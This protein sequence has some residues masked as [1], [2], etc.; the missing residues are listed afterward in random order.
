MSNVYPNVDNQFEE[1]RDMIIARMEKDAEL[2]MHLTSEYW[3]DEPGSG[4]RCC[5]ITKRYSIAISKVKDD[6]NKQDK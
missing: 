6:G 3:K 2:L 1:I 4:E 5:F